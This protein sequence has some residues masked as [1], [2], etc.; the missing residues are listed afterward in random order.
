[1]EFSRNHRKTKK[2]EGSFLMRVFGMKTMKERK[3]MKES[4]ERE[5]KEYMKKEMK[6]SMKKGEE[7]S[8]AMDN[9]YKFLPEKKNQQNIIQVRSIPKLGEYS[10]E[11]YKL[12][13][14]M[15]FPNE[16]KPD[17]VDAAI[18]NDVHDK[19]F[20]KLATFFY[21][22]C[23]GNYIDN[24][25]AKIKI[26]KISQFMKDEKNVNVK[27]NINEVTADF[28]NVL[29]KTRLFKRLL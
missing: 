5:M 8:N 11:E 16:K 4:R 1:M 19:L 6:E 18:K 15:L 22:V 3:E 9:F 29:L 7:L 2:R 24:M 13:Y 10:E 23:S 14:P 26:N 21:Q 20:N 27:N 17:I 12:L 28:I 25:D